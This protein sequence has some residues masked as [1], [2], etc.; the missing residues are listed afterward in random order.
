M[1]KANDYY[2]LG[3]KSKLVTIYASPA[4]IEHGTGFITTGLTGTGANDNGG[5]MF[6]SCNKLVGGSGTKYTNSAD[7]KSYKY[8]HI[9]GGASNKGYFTEKD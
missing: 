4:D 9:D 6:D 5:N 8:A 7:G 2:K 1:F 3:K